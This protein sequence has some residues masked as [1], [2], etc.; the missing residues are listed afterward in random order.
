[1]VANE[2]A[3]D[4]TRIWL[5]DPRLLERQSKGIVFSKLVKVFETFIL[6]YQWPITI[7]T[8]T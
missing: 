1:M 2:I 5:P 7:Q 4:Q 3:W 6:I 8:P